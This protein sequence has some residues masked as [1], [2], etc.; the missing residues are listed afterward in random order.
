VLYIDETHLFNE[1]E[2]S[3]FHNLLKQDATNIVFTID[4]SQA[5]T[6]SAIDADRIHSVFG[7]SDAEERFGLAASPGVV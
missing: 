3:L 1:N 5:A 7:N 6:D 4:R 2:L